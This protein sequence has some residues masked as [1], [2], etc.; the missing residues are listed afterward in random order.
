MHL[1]H[2]CRLVPETRS[3]EDDCLGNVASLEI[4]V[5]ST[6]SSLVGNFWM[7]S[8]YHESDGIRSG[9]DAAPSALAAAAATRAHDLP[10]LG[11]RRL[12][13]HLPHD[14]GEH[15][16]D[17]GLVLG[18]ALDEG[19]APYLREGHPLHRRHLPLPLEVH[20]VAHQEDGHPLRPL[21]A[22]YLVSHRLDVLRFFR[23]GAFK[24]G[25]WDIAVKSFHSMIV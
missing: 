17:V 19:A 2:E 23:D 8:L 9:D 18:A 1:S 10:V 20:L 7:I 6:N 16:V 24:I 3:L 15:L 13:I 21:H 5:S 14:L 11:R 4:V 25:R 22:G 12:E